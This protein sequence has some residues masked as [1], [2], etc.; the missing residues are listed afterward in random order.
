MGNS[1]KKQIFGLYEK[2][3]YTMDLKYKVNDNNLG[4][5]IGKA[6][7]KCQSLVILKLQILGAQLIEKDAIIS[8]KNENCTKRIGPK[9]AKSI[10]EGLKYC[11]NLL[12]LNIT[13]G[14][15]NNIGAVGA[16]SLGNGIKFC[17][18]LI[19]LS[20][21]IKQN[22]N[23]GRDGATGIGDSFKFLF[24]LNS[25]SIDIQE[26]FIGSL[27]TKGL[28]DSL[29][30]ENN[31]QYL[32][33]YFGQ[34]NNIGSEGAKEVAL[35]LQAS[36]KL[37]IFKLFVGKQNKIGVD[38][39]REIG[40][41][42]QNC[43]YL[44]SLSLFLQNDIQKEGMRFLTL[45]VQQNKCLSELEFSI[46][47]EKDG[48]IDSDSQS[49]YDFGSNIKNLKQLR[50][51]KLELGNNYQIGPGGVLGLSIG[52]KSSTSIQSVSIGVHIDNLIGLEGYIDLGEG[53]KYCVS[54]KNLC[55][56]VECNPQEIQY[57]IS[58]VQLLQKCKNLQNLSMFIL[59]LKHQQKVQLLNQI[60]KIDQLFNYKLIKN[61]S[62]LY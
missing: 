37:R 61:F 16:I 38:G 26:D 29:K 43:E 41:R 8:S 40:M 1:I 22:N 62:L 9:G 20:I 32:S 4:V 34:K 35:V 59:N 50:K 23:I 46:Q 18:N 11:H 14:E 13:I 3:K 58:M 42:I 39:A 17:S 53:L 60:F 19:T 30:N 21:T 31:I 28:L 10:G 36:K 44:E 52:L 5:Y 15:N 7:K 25:L 51:L 45:G 24:H 57:V 12:N 49:L 27:G 56:S 55:F 33:L 48:G 6:L 54:L 2:D 47:K